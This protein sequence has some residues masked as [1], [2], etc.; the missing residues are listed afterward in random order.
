MPPFR[1]HVAL[2]RLISRKPSLEHTHDFYEV[3]LITAGSGIH[4]LNRTHIALTTGHIGVVRPQDRHCFSSRRGDSLSILNVA[5]AAS[6]WKQFHFLMGSAIPRMW[7]RQGSPTGHILLDASD[8]RDLQKMFE[9][10]AGRQSH[11]P[12]DLVEVLLQVAAVFDPHAQH[13]SPPAWLE[14][15]RLAIA[16]AEEKV[17]EPLA[18][19]QK[20]SGRSPEHLARSCRAFYQLTPTDILNHARIERAKTLLRYTDDKIITVS[21]T[22]GFDNLSNFYRNFHASVGVTPTAWRRRQS[23]TI[24]LT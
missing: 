2:T 18:Y 19:W 5:I 8:R 24:P 14:Q 20:Q 23:A 16:N 7:F 10:L 6:W 15:W 4:H 9:N 13:T 22:C 3:F 11:P 12:S 21:F 1:P 17:S